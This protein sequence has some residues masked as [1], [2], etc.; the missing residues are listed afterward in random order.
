MRRSTHRDSEENGIPIE[1]AKSKATLFRI[2]E[3]SAWFARSTQV[4]AERSP[5]SGRNLS[6]LIWY[7]FLADFPR[8]VAAALDLAGDGPHRGEVVGG[9]GG[10]G[11]VL[12]ADGRRCVDRV[13]R[14]RQASTG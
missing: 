9:V 13:L 12:G 5:S 1:F 11:A 10:A 3:A 7:G 2:S 6:S 4:L 8:V 14:P